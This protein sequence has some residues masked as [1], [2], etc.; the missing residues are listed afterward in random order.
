MA[1]SEAFRRDVSSQLDR[2]V[3]SEDPEASFTFA[4]CLSAEERKYIHNLA[5]QFGLRHISKGAGDGRRI[6]V[7]KDLSKSQR[8][9]L[10]AA[11]SGQS[12]SAA[13]LRLSLE[14]WDALEHP[15]VACAARVENAEALA[16]SAPLLGVDAHEAAR[17]L[18][19]GGAGARRRK[20]APALCAAAVTGPP[21]TPL[22]AVRRA[23]PAWAWREEVLR[24][25]AGHRVVIIEGA[26][27]CG[28]STQVPQ[29]VLESAAEV[30]SIVVTQ[31]RRISA[32]GLAHRVAQERGEAVGQTVGYS[33]HLDSSSGPSTRLLFCTTGVFRRRLLAEPSLPG[34][35]HLVLDELHERD[36]VTDFLLIAV[37][38]LL[39]ER[40]DLRLILMS[41]TMEHDTFRRY[42]ADC[43]TVLIPGRTF[44]VAE[45][46][47]EDLAPSLFEAGCVDALGPGF[48]AGGLGFGTWENKG[49]EKA[50]KYQVLVSNAH[51]RD[52]LCGFRQNAHKPLVGK[53]FNEAIFL[54]DV[55]QQM[56]GVLFDLPII[57]AIIVALVEGHDLCLE[58]GHRTHGCGGILVFLPGWDDI[59]RLKKRLERHPVIGDARRF[60][61]L[62]LHSQVRLEDQRKV[63]EAPPPGVR[64]LVISTNIAETSITVDDIEVVIDCGRAKEMSYD[65][66]LRVP[67]LNTSWVSRA[68]A[69][70]RAGR[71]GRT[72]PG[73]CLH[74]FS[75]N[76]EALLDE[77]KPPEMLRSPLED[78]CL[79]A[80][81]LLLQHGRPDSPAG[82]YLRLAPDPPDARSVL[83]AEL[84]LSEMGALTGHSEG[85]LGEPSCGRLT[86]LGIHLSALPLQP[87]FAKIVLWAN[88]FGVLDDALAVLGCLQYRDPFVSIGDA[89]RPASQAEANKYIRNAKRT[90]CGGWCTS[91]HLAWLRASEG[92]REARSRGGSA[93]RDFC[94]QHCLSY[95]A[96]VAQQESSAKLLRELAERGL[97]SSAARRNTGDPVLLSAALCAGLFPNVAC[98]R[99]ASAPTKLQASNGRLLAQPHAASVLALPRSTKESKQGRAARAG[100]GADDDEDDAG[101]AGGNEQWL[102]FNE[103]TQIEDHYSLSGLTSVPASAIVLLCGEGDLVVRDESEEQVAGSS[104]AALSNGPGSRRC[105]T[106]GLD[107][108]PDT[109][110]VSVLELGS[111]FCLRVPRETANQ[112]SALRAMLRLLFRSLC[113]NPAVLPELAAEGTVGSVVLELAARVLRGEG[114]VDATAGAW[115]AEGVFPSRAEALAASGSRGRRSAGT[116]TDTSAGCARRGARRAPVDEVLV[117]EAQ[118]EVA[119]ASS[120][121]RAAACGGSAVAA[122]AVQAMSSVACGRLGARAL[123]AVLL[124][125]TPAPKPLVPA[126]AAPTTQGSPFLPVQVTRS[127]TV[128]LARR[129]QKGGKCDHQV[130]DSGGAI[131]VAAGVAPRGRVG[132]A[133]TIVQHVAEQTAYNNGGIAAATRARIAE[134]ASP[135][136]LNADLFA[137]GAAPTDDTATWM[138]TADVAKP[139]AKRAALS[140]AAAPWVAGGAAGFDCEE[141]L[142]D[143]VAASLSRG[144][145][146]GHVGTAAQAEQPQMRSCSSCQSSVFADCGDLDLQTG[147]WYCAWCWQEYY[148][149]LVANRTNQVGARGHKVVRPRLIEGRP[150]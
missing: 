88:L 71:A 16:Q 108:S 139:E 113:S 21:E 4:S 126:V 140:A 6:T 111:W 112:L 83:M 137:A 53:R 102:I 98:Q 66:S 1:T 20:A 48:A 85:R 141:S 70:Q 8:R 17:L 145:C 72:A 81:L 121:R 23:L 150:S 28:K 118:E 36:K 146:A 76:R 91:D 30:G 133:A 69:K 73:F 58:R 39:E 89:W 87:Q 40:P 147:G 18:R 9:G 68:S 37:R 34:I 47:L 115:H 3:G 27:G 105:G 107:V 46:Y 103:L 93:A 38:Q 131:A 29:F 100:H 134:A 99:R 52:G 148:G 13:S 19:G 119:V 101:H 97:A 45:Y 96:L 67:T 94:Q 75:R 2:V 51:H 11:G 43:I 5:E 54:H 130:A 31:P 49:N 143:D 65:S 132:D 74:L 106:S 82:D 109:V 57:E 122:P 120:R 10:V 77:H 60:R 55:L 104:P 62:P 116:L 149:A 59:D 14:A 50:F 95:H 86:A 25:V 136:A 124:S 92:F 80:K 90:L 64:K 7:S 12:G 138:A 41:A 128:A 84:L 117:A 61:I 127:E 22:L 32:L 110:V 33:V 114:Q 56:K 78:V 125:A 42:F 24:A 135:L 129:R 142:Q 79:H 63:F 144:I 35:T 26:T 44:P 15:L 123:A